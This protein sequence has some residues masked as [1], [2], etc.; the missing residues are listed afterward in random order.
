MHVFFM[1]GLGPHFGM[2]SVASLAAPGL[3]HAFPG[4]SNLVNFGVSLVG[5]KIHHGSESFV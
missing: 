4:A 2:P 3:R 1:L 5:F